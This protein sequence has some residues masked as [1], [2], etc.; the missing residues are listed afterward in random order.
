MPERL[1]FTK[2]A[3]EALPPAPTGARVTYQDTECNGLTLRV[4]DAGAKSFI[5][6]RRVN[7][8]PERVT[9]GRF[10]E[11]TIEQ[12]RKVIDAATARPRRDLTTLGRAESLQALAESHLADTH[13]TQLIHQAGHPA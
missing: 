13:L 2:R 4:T 9:L 5:V 8:K 10:P 1:K 11:M 7:G 3:L 6:Q 12:A